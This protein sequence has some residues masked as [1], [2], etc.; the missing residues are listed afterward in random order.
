MKPDVNVDLVGPGGQVQGNFA[1]EII[2]GGRLDPGALK[3]YI[4][5]RGR[6]Y[7]TVYK[8]G[9]PKKPT[10]YQAVP[11]THATLRRDEWKSLDDAI[12][13]IAETRLG[14]VQDLISNGLTFT[15]G[16]AMGTTVLEWHDVSDALEAD[17]TMDGVTRAEGDRVNFQ[18]NYLPIP[19]IHADYE[20][21]SR[22]LAASRSLGNPLDTTMAERA[23]RKVNQ[24]LEDMLFTNT[25]YQFGETDDRSRNTIY[26]YVNHPDRNTY[27]C[28]TDWDDS[29]KSSTQLLN[30]VIGMKQTSIDNKHFGP[31]MLYI[32]TGYETVLDKDYDVTTPGTTIRDRILKIGGIKGV[33]VI[34]TLP[35]DNVL[36][37]QMTPD[38]VRL[39][40]GLG[41][42][43][44]EWTTEGKFIHKYKVLAIQV[45]Q[46]RSDQNGKTGIVHMTC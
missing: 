25:T 18:H 5:S 24:K 11:V 29:S 31:W 7:I 26:S 20:I 34:D 4:D 8:G 46:I 9:D 17:I 39:V 35:A 23:A 33:K 14:G 1:N 32:P 10:S 6:A 13:K 12:R 44:V 27:T 19:I 36:L 38:V 22:V 30:E 45:P 37:V 15:L 21:N 43:N 2:S 41:I 40:Q 16:N 28:G 3:P 42:Q